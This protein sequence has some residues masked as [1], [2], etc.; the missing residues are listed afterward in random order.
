MNG[1][2]AVISCKEREYT[3][4]ELTKIAEEWLQ[5]MGYGANPYLIVFHSDTKNNHVHMVS[6]RIGIDGKK[7]KDNMERVN[8][9]KAINELMSRDTHR[10]CQQ[11]IY[12][13][14]S[15]SFSTVNQAKLFLE[16]RG[17]SLKEEADFI[18]LF[19][20]GIFNGQISN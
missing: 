17:Y 10:E 18:K 15:Y 9:Q 14:K 19:K 16:N 2:H 4:I 6:S 3:K 1:F 11:T 5:K 8:G 12:E 20:Y 13:L 7:I